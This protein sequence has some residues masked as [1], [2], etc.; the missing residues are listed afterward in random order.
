MSD[1]VLESLVFW[2]CNT[3]FN[4]KLHC[5]KVFFFQMH[6]I[7]TFGYTVGRVNIPVIVITGHCSQKIA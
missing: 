1:S 7:Q 3:S 6:F 2:K 4:D 5:K